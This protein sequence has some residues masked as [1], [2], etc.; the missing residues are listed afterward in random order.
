MTEFSTRTLQAKQDAPL[1]LIQNSHH[2]AQLGCAPGFALLRA[3]GFAISIIA[4]LG[5]AS[6]ENHLF[7]VKS[8][9][10]FALANLKF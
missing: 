3:G 7:K 9:P 1:T 8:G 5:H 4:F 6:Q 10:V 2:G